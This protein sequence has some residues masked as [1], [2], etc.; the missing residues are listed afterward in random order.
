[1]AII[2]PD[3]DIHDFGYSDMHRIMASCWEAYHVAC[4]YY[5]QLQNRQT[6]YTLYGPNSLHLGILAAGHLC[7]SKL[8]KLSIKTSS[9]KYLKY[10]FDKDYN[11][12][13][14]VKMTNYDKVYCTHHIFEEDGVL[15]CCAFKQDRNIH[16]SKNVY[17]VKYVNGDPLY[18]AIST[19]QT[20]IIDLYEYP[21]PY[22]V[23]TNSYLYSPSSKYC[24][25]GLKASWSAP[26]GAQDSPVTL[27]Y[28]DEEY[29][30]LNFYDYLIKIQLD[31]QSC[32]LKEGQQVDFA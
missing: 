18:F 7:P 11:L 16:T 32:V 20:L 29:A 21:T 30:H 6:A 31:H 22:R 26:L 5:D 14:I 2:N 1:M 13:R 28:C 27:D 25:T 24:S 4:T 9:K 17:A 10:E 23:K 15:F 12:L 8:R 3:I 19:P